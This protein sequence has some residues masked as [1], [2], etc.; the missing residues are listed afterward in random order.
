MRKKIKKAVHDN[1]DDEQK[2]HLQIQENKRKKRKV[3]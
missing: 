1:L 2:E 3:T